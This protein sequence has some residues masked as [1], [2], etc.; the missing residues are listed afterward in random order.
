ML[1]LKNDYNKLGRN[2]LSLT[3]WNWA[4]GK[5]SYSVFCS[6]NNESIKTVG[7]DFLSPLFASGSQVYLNQKRHLLL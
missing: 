6:G 4:E 1:K 7:I 2:V 3:K 5:K